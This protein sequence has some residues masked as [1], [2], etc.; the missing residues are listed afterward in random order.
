MLTTYR[1]YGLRKNSAPVKGPMNG[2]FCRGDRLTGFRRRCSHRAD[3]GEDLVLVKNS[4]GCFDGLFRLIA[5]VQRLQFKFTARNPAGAIGGVEGCQ[6]S[7]AHAL[8]QGLR[9]PLQRRHLA[10]NNLAVA[11]PVLGERGSADN[12]EGKS[13]RHSKLIAVHRFFP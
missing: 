5:V 4:L 1:L 8:P 2:T 3:Q 12:A 11:D 7:L 9:R 6:N 10:K 13:E